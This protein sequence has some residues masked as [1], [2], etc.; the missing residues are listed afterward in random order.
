MVF[1][2]VANAK[3]AHVERRGVIIMMRNRIFLTANLTGLTNKPVL[4]N[5]DPNG[6]ASPTPFR[7]ETLT[8]LAGTFTLHCAVAFAP[9]ETRRAL[10]LELLPASLASPDGQFAAPNF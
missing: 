7:A 2:V 9:A 8:M 1:P 10:R 4:V 5:R 6:V 3:P